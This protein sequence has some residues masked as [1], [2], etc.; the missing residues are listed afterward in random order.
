LFY[1]WLGLFNLFPFMVWKYVL[2]RY[3]KSKTMIKN[4]DGSVIY[5]PYERL[6][7]FE[8]VKE[9]FYLFT[10]LPTIIKVLWKRKL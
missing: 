8:R 6:T 9:L 10:I 4:K 1:D 5:E 2:L 3:V 7:Y